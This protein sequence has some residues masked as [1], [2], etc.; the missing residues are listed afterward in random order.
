[1]KKRY[2]F[3]LRWNDQNSLD[4]IHRNYANET[5]NWRY[6]NKKKKKKIGFQSEQMCFSLLIESYRC[7]CVFEDSFSVREP[8]KSGKRKKFSENLWTKQRLTIKQKWIFFFSYLPD[9]YTLYVTHVSNKV[10]CKKRKGHTKKI[11]ENKNRMCLA[12]Q[13]YR[14]TP[15]TGSEL[16]FCFYF[17]LSLSSL[18]IPKWLL[19]ANNTKGKFLPNNLILIVYLMYNSSAESWYNIY[20]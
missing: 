4:Y 12:G 13:L 1:M 15:D 11:K 14:P 19:R 8:F 7:V 9:E 10:Q 6:E 16:L 3:F 17:S 20:I 5:K 18:V 2:L